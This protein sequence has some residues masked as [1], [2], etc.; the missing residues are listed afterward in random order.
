MAKK[1]EGT[2]IIK[3]VKKGGH[4][5]H[6]G[7]AWKV[8]Y[9]D[10]V[11]AMMAFFLLLWLLNVTTDVQK[12]GIADYF[13]PA[14]ALKTAQSGADGILGGRVIGEPG[15]MMV[16]ASAP[17]LSLPI[18][19]LRQPED[20][21]EGND[22]GARG[23]TEGDRKDPKA[24]KLED[25][26]RL[27]AEA[28]RDPAKLNDPEFQKKLASLEERQFAAAEFALR[29]AIEDVPDLRN[30]AENLLIDRTPEGL[31]IQLVDQEKTAMFAL[32]STEMQQG[33]RKLMAQ[34]ARVVQRLPNKISVSG[35]TDAQPYARAGNYGNWELSTDR[36]N[37][38]RRELLAQG[39][40]ADRIAKVVG[41]ADRDPLFAAE[42]LSPKNRRISIVLLREATAPAGTTLAQ[43]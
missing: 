23:R 25:L 10:F 24:E 12:R 31:R 26:E 43:R 2:I 18:P 19:A 21:D 30:L 38:S 13:D 33:A 1:G 14:I 11:T 8:A 4:D 42:P 35:H 41:M 5:G 39:L 22:D 32:G 27:R 17:S 7:G 16:S 36:A 40:A 37:A 34:V 15:A 3:R 20:G 29:Q 6:H 9:A 28:K